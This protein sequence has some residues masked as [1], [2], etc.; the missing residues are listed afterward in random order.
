[1]ILLD[2][3]VVIFG[4]IVVVL[5]P[6]LVILD[7]SMVLLDKNMNVKRLQR[8]VANVWGLVPRVVVSTEKQGLEIVIFGNIV[9]VLDPTL[10][11][12][13]HSMVLLDKNMNVKRLQ[14]VVANVWGLVP[15]VVVSTEKQGLEIRTACYVLNRVLVTS[16][17][18][19]TP[20]AL[21]TGNIPSVSQ[22]KPFGYHVNILNTSD[23]LG[24]KHVQANQSAGTQGATTNLADTQDANSDSNYDEQIIIVP[25]YPSH[26]I[27][28]TE[29]KDTS[30]DE[31]DD[32]L[33]NSADES[34]Q[35]ELARMKGQEQKA[36]SDA[37]SLGLG[38]ANDVEKLQKN[39][40][41]KTVPP[42][43]LLVPTGYIP[44]PVGATMVSTD[45]VPVHSSSSNDSLFDDEPTTRFLCPSDLGNHDPPPGIF[46]SSSYDDEFD[47]ALNNVAST[48]EVSLVAPRQI[49]TIHPQSLIIG[50]PT[51]AVQTRKKVKQTTTVE[52]RSVAQALE[53]P[54]WVDAIQEEMQQF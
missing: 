53:D 33:L 9:V 1:M 30:G 46:S 37:E 48:V 34:F 39:A 54:S 26:N 25:S 44:V 24:Y 51:L 41:T 20:Y 14:R 27:L 7:H 40:S 36:T 10:V 32:S 17:H 12:L 15:R 29:P 50:D 11:I 16:P 5:D 4:N 47:A 6:T 13:D 35:K 19:K 42:G 28:G 18:N 8:V 31:V 45:D 3:V 43:S 52:P 49:N 23:H 21:L 38:F 22:F 2:L